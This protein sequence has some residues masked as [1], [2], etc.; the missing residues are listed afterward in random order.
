MFA[1]GTS[2]TLEKLVLTSL[3]YCAHFKVSKVLQQQLRLLTHKKC[4]RPG[5]DADL[6][7]SRTIFELRLTQSAELISDTDLN[8]S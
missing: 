8:S 2:L 5:S 3:I 6:F 4:L 1:T 7:M